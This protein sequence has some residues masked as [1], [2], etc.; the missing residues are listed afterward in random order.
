MAEAD[1]AVKAGH[2]GRAYAILSTAAGANRTD[3]APWLRMAQL[4]FEDKK[5]GEAIVSGLEAIE[6]DPD[7]MLAYSLVAVS[8]LRV[9]SK[10]LGDLSEKSGFSGS[11]HSEAQ[12]L[13]KLLH[14]TL[15]LEKI[16]PV[17]LGEVANRPTETKPASVS[18]S[19]GCL[20]PFCVRK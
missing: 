15:K 3:K 7:D 4:H 17:K 5:Y 13:T 16:V 20:G 19:K 11:V 8:A 6:R 10:A 2:I 9:A 18:A 1:A 12:D 14:S